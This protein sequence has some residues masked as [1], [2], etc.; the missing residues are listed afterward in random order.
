VAQ[1]AECLPSKFIC[2]EFK[3]Q[4]QQQQQKKKLKEE[5]N[6]AKYLN[7]CLTKDTQIINKHIKRFSILYVNR[8]LQIKMSYLGWGCS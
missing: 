4:Y 1:V 3:F 5:K 8:G 2:P 6:W 7:R